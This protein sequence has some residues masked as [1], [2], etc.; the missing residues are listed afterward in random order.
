MPSINL[1]AAARKRL[2]RIVKALARGIYFAF[3]VRYYL[4]QG[5]RLPR[6]FEL[7]RDTIYR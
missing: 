7:A 2:T 4:K 6:A 5:H 3:D 1:R